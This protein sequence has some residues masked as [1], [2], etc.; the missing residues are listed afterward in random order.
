MLNDQARIAEV[1]FLES[2]LV[3]EEN[4][5]VG[6]YSTC[7]NYGQFIFHRAIENKDLAHENSH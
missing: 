4:T 7:T 1:S 6:S 2:R 3:L 5:I